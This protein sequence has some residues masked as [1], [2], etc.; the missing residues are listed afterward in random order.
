MLRN[1]YYNTPLVHR[2]H[3]WLPHDGALNM[4]PSQGTQFIDPGRLSGPSW[5]GYIPKWYSC[6]RQSP[7]PV[8]TG[9]N[10]EFMRRTMLPLRQT[11]HTVLVTIPLAVILPVC[12]HCTVCKVSKIIGVELVCNWLRCN[13]NTCT[14]LPPTWHRWHSRLYTSA[15]RDW[16]WI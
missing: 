13:Q 6:Q 14:V 7:I 12:L 10:V 1:C 8:L 11:D 5:L 4:R 3:E 15:S 2:T 9:L 16:Y